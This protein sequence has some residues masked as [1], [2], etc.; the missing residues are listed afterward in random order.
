MD[1]TGYVEIKRF[2]RGQEKTIWNTSGNLSSSKSDYGNTT[3]DIKER[4]VTSQ[5]GASITNKCFPLFP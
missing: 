5:R 2:T 4:F 1:E 3:L